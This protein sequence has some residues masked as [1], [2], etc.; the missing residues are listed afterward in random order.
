M[1]DVE[2]LMEI[3]NELLPFHAELV[4]VSK[5]KP[6][7][8]IQQ[9]YTAGQ[10]I[11]GENYVQEVTVKQQE[12]PNDIQWHFIG[13]LQSNKVKQIASVVNLIHSVD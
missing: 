5:L 11:F 10:K 8:E 12:L 1:A 4:A 6:T 7:S 2:R 3:K 13:H 9:L